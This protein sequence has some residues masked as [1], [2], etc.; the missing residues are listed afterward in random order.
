MLT[1][2]AYDDEHLITHQRH[3]LKFLQIYMYNTILTLTINEIIIKIMN[4]QIAIFLC[5][6]SLCSAIETP[7]LS[8]LAADTSKPSEATKDLETSASDRCKYYSY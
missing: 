4:L 5:A 6:I 2:I 8:K 1:L 7:E 3:K